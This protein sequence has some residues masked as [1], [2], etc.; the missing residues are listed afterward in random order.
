MMRDVAGH[1]ANGGGL[2]LAGLVQYTKGITL[3]VILGKTQ[4]LVFNPITY[5]FWVAT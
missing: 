3:N 2:G 5:I 1:G 4:N